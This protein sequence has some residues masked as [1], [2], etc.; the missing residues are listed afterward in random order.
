MAAVE[1]GRFLCS[2]RDE[3]LS[4]GVQEYILAWSFAVCLATNGCGGGRIWKLR[5]SSPGVSFPGFF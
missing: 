5:F 1:R 4:E 2:G 3:H